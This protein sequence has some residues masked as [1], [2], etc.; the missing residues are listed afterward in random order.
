MEL[1]NAT[2]IEGYVT[3]YNTKN[4]GKHLLIDCWGCS[5]YKN[6]SLIEDILRKMAQACGVHVLDVK[7]H[8][9]GDEGGVTGVALLSESHISIHTWPE[10]DYIALDVFV[11]GGANPELSLAVIDSMLMPGKKEMR[12][13]QRGDM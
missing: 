12:M 2:C 6:L 1:G 8:A 9:F 4:P 11:C 5:E 3:E 10:L 7:L 13:I